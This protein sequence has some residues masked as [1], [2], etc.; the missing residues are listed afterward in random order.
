M[1]KVKTLIASL[2]IILATAFMS[3]CSCGGD[4]SSDPIIPVTSITITSDFSGATQ[5]EESKYLNIRCSVNQEFKI[6]YHLNPENTTRT[7]V[8]WGFVGSDG[9]VASK[10]N[11]YTYSQSANE[12]VTFVA[13]RVGNPLIIF[14]LPQYLLF[15]V[16]NKA[17]LP[18]FK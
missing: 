3:A 5:D 8:D 13:K 10:N 14:S 9:V 4:N 12:T 1:K 7:Q 16:I 17:I 2:A 15:C 6:T 18:K 11:R